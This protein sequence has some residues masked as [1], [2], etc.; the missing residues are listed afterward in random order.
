MLWSWMYG[1]FGVACYGCW[2]GP[3]E[4][5]PVLLTAGRSLQPPL[6]MGVVV[7]GGQGTA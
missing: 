5:Q 6:R 4:G 2:E 7:C 1:W 3:L